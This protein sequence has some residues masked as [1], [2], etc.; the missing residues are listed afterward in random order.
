MATLELT[1]IGMIQTVIGVMIVIA[2][3]SNSALFLLV[4]S[5]LFDGS[6]AILLPALGGSSIPPSQFAL[7]FVVLR[8]LAPKG[9]SYGYLPEALRANAW[10][11]LFCLYGM[12]LA[13]IG[14]RLFGGSIDVFPMRP[15]P[16]AGPFD[17][18]PLYPTS[19]NLTAAFYLLGTLLIA[20]ASYVITRSKD[21]SKTLVSAAI[22]GGWFFVVTGLLD[23]VTRGTPLEQIL[24]VFRNGN[25]TQLNAEVDG[26]IR[27]RGLT[28]EASSFASY[29]FAFFVVN[30]ELWYRSIRTAQTGGMAL[31]LA[32]M[33]IF[34][35][36]STAYV[37]LTVYAAAFLLRAF[38]FPKLAPRGKLP[39]A[40]LVGFWA[41]VLVS[42]MLA[43]VPELPNAI[44]QIIL[45]MTVEKS[46]SDSGLQRLFWA[47]QGWQAVVAS[48]GL[49]IGPGSFRSSS[50]VMAIVGSMG[51]IGVASFGLY[52]LTVLKPLRKS[53]WGMG[54]DLSQTLG[55][56][57][58]DAAIL[59]LIPAAI[60]SSQASPDAIF[61]VLAG[62]AL[63][64]R[65]PRFA[66]LPA[67]YQP[68]Q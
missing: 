44:Y 41:L 30:A 57:F 46:S 61:S 29:C 23:V 14:P 24:D 63:A 45:T 66:R 11:V 54:Q 43:L 10:L 49:G 47:M 18:I 4:G 12:A 53:S 3:S 9:G 64:F 39:R 20:L 42:A 33:L 21:T 36:S 26:F 68:A 35:T 37:A 50:I 31:M 32:L 51:V 22:V 5:C 27:I 7:L 62:A 58:A 19:Q 65:P 2:G 8:I 59:S 1:F 25:Y 15:I 17:V 67:Q 6:A 56:A 40:I 55:G 48:Y 38:I 16:G 60:G 13:Y 34:S 52:L 28:P